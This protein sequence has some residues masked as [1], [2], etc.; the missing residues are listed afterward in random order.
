MNR[1]LCVRCGRGGDGLAPM[2]STGCDHG[3]GCEARACSAPAAWVV[4]DKGVQRE[5]CLE[6]RDWVLESS[7]TATTRP[8]AEAS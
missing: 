6:H 8:L 2:D 4:R 3:H 1:D 7:P 5:V